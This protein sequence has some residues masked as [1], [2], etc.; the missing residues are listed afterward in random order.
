MVVD[1]PESTCPM[2]TM[3]MCVFSFPMLVGYVWRAGG[4]GSAGDAAEFMERL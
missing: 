4:G 3:L 1:F 2:T